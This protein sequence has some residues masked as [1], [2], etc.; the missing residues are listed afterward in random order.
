MYICPSVSLLSRKTPPVA[1]PAD[2]FQI[3]NLN[4]AVTVQSPILVHY[5]TDCRLTANQLTRRQRPR[6]FLRNRP[7][8]SNSI[9]IFKHNE[10]WSKII[11]KMV[12]KIKGSATF[13]TFK[14]LPLLPY[15]SNL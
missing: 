15:D 7:P 13:P 14:N 11:Y 3:W 10:K 9:L 4:C 2:V 6:N 12:Q 5:H 1:G 8:H